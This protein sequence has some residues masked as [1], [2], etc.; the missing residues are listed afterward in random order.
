MYDPILTKPLLLSQYFFAFVVFFCAVC[1]LIYIFPSVYFCCFIIP[2]IF[3]KLLASLLHLDTLFKGQQ[4]KQKGS[5]LQEEFV[6]FVRHPAHAPSH[7]KPTNARY[8]C[9][10]ANKD[11]VQC[12]VLRVNTED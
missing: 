9:G 12:V 7:W 4:T 8:V 3:F 1:Q 10:E 6:Q 5:S 2:V 11:F